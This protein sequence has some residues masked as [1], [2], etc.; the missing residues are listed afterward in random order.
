MESNSAAPL[1]DE[2]FVLDTASYPEA[3]P[4]LSELLQAA[5]DGNVRRAALAELRKGLHRALRRT[6]EGRAQH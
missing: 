6:A 3:I 5:M 1:E 2:E 4:W